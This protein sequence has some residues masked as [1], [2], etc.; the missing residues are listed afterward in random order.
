MA[1][2][3]FQAGEPPRQPAVSSYAG[4]LFDA[5]R[6]AG[7][8][9]LFGL[10][11]WASVCLALYVAFWLELPNAYWAGTSAAIVCQP[12]LGA[13]LRKGW[14]RL[15]GTV[16]GAIA[17]VVLT[18]CFPQ[19]RAPFLVFLALW[20]AGCA[21][22]AT[23]LK[24][25]AAYSAALAG[26]TVA[27]IASDQLG[28]TGGPN[29]QAFML[30]VYRASEIC[31]GIV[32][33]GL[34]L[35]LTDFGGARRRVASL[36]A[37]LSAE[38]ACRFTGTLADAGAG[39][40]ETQ[41]IRRELVRRVIA[42]DPVI[43]EALGESSE[44]R[45][46][47]PVLQNALDGLVRALASWR[48]VAVVLARSHQ[49][50]ARQE[51]AALLAEVPEQLRAKPG[52]D[53][54]ARWIAHPARLLQ[55]SEAA[56]RNLFA[57]PAA[58]PSLRLLA[59][60]AAEAL[61]GVSQALVALAL[62]VADPTRRIDNIRGRRRLRIPDW[63]PPLVNA[64]R[65]FVVIGAAELFWIVTAWPGGANAITFAA[66]IAI[67]FAPRADQAYNMAI[68]FMI[69]SVLTVVIVAS[70][71]FAALPNVETFAGFGLI[72]GLVLVPVGT[73]FALQWEPAI[74][75]GMIT[76]FVPLL[77]PSNPM[78]YDTQQYYNAAL[79]IIAGAGA[80]ALS[81][82]LLPPLSP[83]YRTRRLLA[84]TLRDFRRLATGPL[85]G[86]PQDW[87]QRMYARFAL[88]PDQAQPLQRSW[89]TAALSAGTKIIRLRHLHQFELSPKLGAA[90]EAI[91]GADCARAIEI[92]AE[93]DAALT[94]R[95]GDAALRARG[96][97]LAISVALT[98]HA[99]YFAAG[100]P[101]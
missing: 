67:L 74:F 4:R 33:A 52:E 50:R 90:L 31:I 53:E 98:Q 101:G 19:D 72:I 27:I 23:L 100:E 36:F 55:A 20:G 47:S 37:H 92:L 95:P 96:L 93:I 46:H 45:Y 65:V 26:Y 71:L 86:T 9:L 41:T 5:L 22:V 69:G 3:E 12:H 94:A 82:R 63:L 79:T 39:F 60:Q 15:I 87:E 54:A 66:I 7:P 25:F 75:T 44:L 32:S 61:V 35:A 18:A 91:A 49:E 10:R 57:V 28:A 8:P 81:Y 30:A 16:I 83:A 51:A 58:T 2:A 14:Y 17:V 1:E 21:F 64:G 84:L 11:L 68:G 42:L 97:I 34:V 62:L 76:V 59:D 43:D 88:L 77:A 56:V 6:A 89:L 80:G 24:N 40:E 85:P 13:S 73:V 48:T 29:G 70:L 78:N 99:A 38:I